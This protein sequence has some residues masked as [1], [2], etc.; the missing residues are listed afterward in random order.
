MF[1]LYLDKNTYMK[2]RES[3][4]GMGWGLVVDCPG[5]LR[6]PQVFSWLFAPFLCSLALI[7]S[8]ISCSSYLHTPLGWVCR[9]QSSFSSNFCCVRASKLSRLLLQS[10]RPRSWLG[11]GLQPILC[12]SMQLSSKQGHGPW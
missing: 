4:S 6:Y 10:T 8:L 12:S 2:F 3:C 9:A 7:F 11:A 5:A 1:W